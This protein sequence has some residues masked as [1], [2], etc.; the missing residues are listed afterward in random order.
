MRYL[1]LFTCLLCLSCNSFSFEDQ[2]FFKKIHENDKNLPET[3]AGDW[4]YD[5]KESGQNFSEY[6]LMSPVRA[7]EKRNIIY[8]Q[9]IGN[10]TPE[11][12]EIIEQDREYL[13][14][15]YQMVVK[16]LP[17][18]DDAIIPKAARRIHSEGHEQWNAKMIL[19]SILLER[20]PDDGIVLMGLSANDLFPKPAWNFVFGLAYLKHKVGVTSIHRLKDYDTEDENLFRKRLLAISSHEI[21]HMFSLKHCIYAR[22][23]MNGSNSLVET[24]KKPNRLCTQCLKKLHW[25]RAFDLK[26]RLENKRDFFERFEMLSD[27]KLAEADAL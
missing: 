10:F 15:F 5:Q 6:K 17:A 14:I 23:V 7:T 26:A 12:K 19:D 20:R 13:E 8:L 16:I 18:L 21:G 3:Q 1:I 4:L 24:D 25:N 27:L 2:A 22:C 9:P 11:Q